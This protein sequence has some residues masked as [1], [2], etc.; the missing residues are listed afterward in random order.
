[1]THTIDLLFAKA[2]LPSGSQDAFHFLS[3]L[4]NQSRQGKPYLLFETLPD[5]LIALAHEEDSPIVIEGAR[6]YLR[7]N[8][9]LE[10]GFTLHLDKITHQT[11][12]THRAPPIP[13][14]LYP[15]Q[16]RAFEAIFDHRLVIVTG[17]PGCGKTYLASKI[18]EAFPAKQII[19][20]AP[21][22]KAAL[23]LKHPKAITKTLHSLLQI[24]QGES[25]SKS[26]RP[27]ICD[28]LVVDECSMI[29]IRLFKLLFESI[30]PHTHILLMGDPDQLPPIQA[31]AIFR[32]LCQNENL[33]TINL[34]E[35]KRTDISSIKQLASYFR[36]GDAK[37]A[38]ELLSTPH[39]PVKRI[40][41]P[42]SPPLMREA[43]SIIIT[44]FKSGPFGT[45]AINELHKGITPSPIM[46]TQNDYKLGLMNGDMGLYQ[47]G[48][49][50]FDKAYPI[51]L[52]SNYTLAFAIS[53]HKS[54]GSEFDHVHLFLP[55]SEEA[56]T[57][58]M[59][60]TAATR[61]RK[62]LTVYCSPETLTSALS[63]AS[64]FQSLRSL[65]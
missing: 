13:I 46:I 8:Y 15:A 1:M 6:C 29:D 33:L 18:I 42:K 21:T 48:I 27:I 35:T 57:R 10:K 37:S 34:N 63:R 24:R 41:L 23:R 14:E 7:R 47:D 54:Q 52:L 30:L 61:A 17:G 16:K 2:L 5:E 56:Y 38:L 62:T 64:F 51:A 11:P 31:G 28:L 53:I 36:E 58:E 40:D 4:F 55:P 19:A 32:D 3:Q 20:T 60:Y 39:L 44:P 59:I 50:T 45:D 22:G 43:N 49:A 12:L 25:F 26:R 65:S 9:D